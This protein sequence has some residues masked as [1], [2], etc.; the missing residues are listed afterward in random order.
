MLAALGVAGC[1]RHSSAP[2]VA[3]TPRY[4]IG[5]SWQGADGTWFYPREQLDLHQTGLA[6]IEPASTDVLTADGEHRDPDAVAGA[7][8]TLQLPAV[9]RVSNLENG[10][11]MLVR[12]NDRGPASS[13]RL[14]AL[15]PAAAR[16]LGMATGR[17]TRIAIVLDPDGSRTV[18]AQA[19]GNPRLDIAAAP[20]EDVQEQSL[21]APGRSGRGGTAAVLKQAPAQPRNASDQPMRPV[22][23]MVEQDIPNPGSLWIDAGQF[24]QRRYADEVATTTNGTVDASGVGRET[25]FRVRIGPFDQVEAADAALDRAH[26]A[27]V[28]GARIIVE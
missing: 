6:V 15:T 26:R 22:Y 7:H 28:T 18:V 23:D 12:I 9:L 27:G 16:L 8:Q 21:D 4:T 13:G 20:V 14:L 24:S 5:A 3:A 17:P 1:Q 19:L 10:R 25:V 11:R 2:V